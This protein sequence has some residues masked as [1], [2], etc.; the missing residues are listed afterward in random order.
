MA[1]VHRYIRVGAGSGGTGLVILELSN[2]STL[3]I[4]IVPKFWAPSACRADINLD[5]LFDSHEDQTLVVP[6]FATL[7]FSSRS[8]DFLARCIA[9]LTGLKF[10][11][12]ID[13]EEELQGIGA[14]ASRRLE[15]LLMETVRPVGFEGLTKLV[16]SDEDP[17]E[18]VRRFWAGVEQVGASDLV[19]LAE[20][21]DLDSPV[22]L[23]R[24]LIRSI[25][26]L[27]MALWRLFVTESERALRRRTPDFRERRDV[28]PFV[29]GALTRAGRFNASVGDR[30]R[31]EC[32]FSELD[33]DHDW[34]RLIRAGVRETASRLRSR[35]AG[36]SEA[37]LLLR[38]QRI[39]IRMSDV[40]LLNSSVARRIN[41]DVARLGKNRHAIYAARLGAAVLGGSIDLGRKGRNP[42]DIAIA[43]GL[44]IS[45]PL[46]FERM[47]VGC[48]DGRQG[49]QLVAN[50][51]AIALRK[52]EPARKLPDLLLVDPTL[53]IPSIDS[54]IALVDA[55]YKSR[56]PT[57]MSQMPM[58]DQYQQFAYAVVARRPALF[59]YAAAPGSVPALLD[60]APANVAEPAPLLAAA[61]VP[62]PG[63]DEDSWHSALGTSLQGTISTFTRLISVQHRQ[64]A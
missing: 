52:G 21:S 37:E 9:K 47:L 16:L 60:L 33:N 29:R 50:R 14:G 34:Q 32:E 63:P 27:Q 62:F 30:T 11:E 46:L 5:V 39:D 31:L 40:K 24:R 2:G 51:E 28:L 48:L 3:S 25:P 64:S 10:D 13:D 54:A 12:S 18:S 58:G 44:R 26:G 4:F 20:G 8:A 17:D 55:K 23:G 45:T 15:S 56:C 42:R 36:R 19:K 7:Q 57:S 43:T 53:P 59:L 49:V 35:N 41:I 6:E 22:L 1:S 38:C 61:S